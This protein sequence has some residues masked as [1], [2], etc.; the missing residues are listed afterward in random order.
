[1]TP[2]AREIAERI[3]RAQKATI[4]TLTAERDAAVHM[5]DKFNLE[6]DGLLDRKDQM[7]L[8]A[9]KAE[10]EVEAL[11]AERDAAK[12]DIERLR[13]SLRAC[14]EAIEALANV[15]EK[16]WV[17][18]NMECDDHDETNKRAEKAEA[19]VETLHNTLAEADAAHA[20]EDAYKTTGKGF[21]PRHVFLRIQKEA[22]SRHRSR[23]TAAPETEKL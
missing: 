8:R 4:E 12:H 19:E 3:A 21:L 18:F 9:E 16:G 7:Q 15:K 23:L 6:C 1:M 17:A 14:E 10:A 13:D 5:R 2:D 20:D 11:T 22:I